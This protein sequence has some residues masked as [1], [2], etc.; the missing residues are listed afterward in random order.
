MERRRTRFPGDALQEIQLVPRSQ[1]SAPTPSP[2]LFVPQSSPD[3]SKT[4]LESPTSPPPK[5][6]RRAVGPALPKQVGTIEEPA[7]SN[8][9]ESRYDIVRFHNPWD[10]YTGVLDE[11]QAGQATVSLQINTERTVV[12]IRRQVT[13]YHKGR[14]VSCKH[15]NIVS[16]IEAFYFDESF[17]FVYELMSVPLAALLHMPGPNLRPFEIATICKEVFTTI[18]N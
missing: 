8:G 2:D 11:D 12:A 18:T 13:K 7:D 1:A 15:Q 5:R 6:Q 16:L 9:Q 4:V 17:Y 3:S 10:Q 14:V